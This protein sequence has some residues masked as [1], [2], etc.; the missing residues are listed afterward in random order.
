MEDIASQL[1]LK[2]ARQGPEHKILASED[3]SRLTLDTIALCVMDYRFNPFYMDEMHPFVQAMNRD[4]AEKNSRNQF[5]GILRGML[6]GRKEA[7]LRDRKFILQT[8]VGAVDTRYAFSQSSG[9]SEGCKY[10][11]ERVLHDKEEVVD[12]FGKGAMV[13][14]CD[15]REIAQE[16]GVAVRELVKWRAERGGKILNS[17]IVE[18]FMKAHEE[19]EV[20]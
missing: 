5:S 6:P 16:L 18:D 13:Y 10:V 8:G 20:R 7:I 12:M 3:F 19:L 15:S 4:L 11:Q 1:M 2:W 9:D 14:T 17:E